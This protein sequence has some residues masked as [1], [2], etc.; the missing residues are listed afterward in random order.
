[1][2]VIHSFEQLNTNKK[3]AIAVGYFDGMHLGHRKL[4]CQMREYAREHDMIPMI[5]T[6][7]MS[8]L[9]AEGKGKKDL[10]PREH[11]VAFAREMGVEVYAE[12][13]FS[14]I[15]DLSPEEFC[16]TVLS[17]CHGL[18]AGAVFCGKDFR[19]GKDRSGSIDELKT[20]GMRIGYSVEIIDDVFI[21]NSIVST[22]RIKEALEAGDIKTVNQ[23]LGEP[24]SIYGEVV[25]GNHL[26]KGMGFPTANILFAP[27]VVIPKKGVYLTETV[28]EEGTFR[29]I[30]NVGTRP[31]VTE[32]MISTAET[33]I[34]GFSGDLY[35]S[36]IKVMF[37][38]FVRPEQKFTSV[39]E[40][41][42]TVLENIE[43]ARNAMI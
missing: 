41:K 12:I 29:S 17:G 9:R 39:D 35:G 21:N 38:E 22:S 20:N 42:Q 14:E 23:M 27:S 6:F 1:M 37:Y 34:L 24:Y 28:I 32:D 40:L 18:D 11:T 26:A 7:D 31:T 2:E 10:F 43:Y 13:P 4:I 5:L 16:N 25:H 3:T 19:F 33:H 8:G 15:K 36:V 30:T